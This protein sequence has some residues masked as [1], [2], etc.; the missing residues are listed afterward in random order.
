MSLRAF[1]APRFALL[2]L[3]LG[4]TLISFSGVFVSLVSVEAT[5]SAFY[6]VLFGGVI[7]LAMAL[8]RWRSLIPPRPVFLLLLMA[9][10][11]FAADLAFWHQSILY[12]GPGLATLLANFQVFCM[13]LAGFVLFRESLSFTRLAAIPLAVLGLVM[14]VGLET[15]VAPRELHYGVAL[16]LATAVWYT[17]F[18]LSMRGAAKRW[19]RG[20]AIAHLALASLVTTL[21]LGVYALWNGTSLILPTVADAAWLVTYGVVGQ[22]V[23]WLFITTALPQVPAATAGLVL[24][25]QPALAYV[26]DV[27]IFGRE[28]S[29]I[30]VGGALLTLFAIFLGTVRRRRAAVPGPV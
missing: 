1:F 26:W 30:Q 12:V 9:A 20:D 14:I 7:L 22:V 8:P 17:G 21:I 25:L 23:G 13:A 24:L 11:F 5:V 2:R 27:L 28:L 6:R 3:V 18:M 10:A 16:G 15:G 29:V 19:G 4:A